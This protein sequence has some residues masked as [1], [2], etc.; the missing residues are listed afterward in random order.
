MS[1]DD[2]TMPDDWGFNQATVNSP[3][4]FT[5]NAPGSYFLPGQ[6]GNG[7]VLL[8][9]GAAGNP[10]NPNDANGT[11][12]DPFAYTNGSLLT[13]WTQQFNY[14]G[15]AAPEGGYF[16]GSAGYSPLAPLNYQDF[17]Y[18]FKAPQAYSYQGD[19]NAPTPFTA[20]R[21][22]APADFQSPSP[23]YQALRYTAPDAFQA[24][25]ESGMQEDPGY[26]F[27][28]KQGLQA[29]ENSAAA[30]GVLRSGNTYKALEDYGQ[31]SASNEYQN[32]YNRR[33]GE[34]TTNANLGLAAF[35]RN[36]AAGLTEN[37]L[38][39]SRAA[40]EYDRTYQNALQRYQMGYQQ[41]SSEH[42]RNF[43]EL[44]NTHNAN[45]TNSLEAWKGNTTADIQGQQLGFNIAS[46]TWDRNY[47]KAQTAYASSVQQAEQAAA[48]GAQNA[49]GAASA[50]E[51]AN[52]TNYNR[53]LGEYNMG[54]EQFQN[55]QVNQFSRIYSQ[56]ALGLQAAGTSS[57]Q[58]GQFA[59]N[60]SNNAT[61]QANANAA[62][63]IASGQA[64][65]NAITGFANTA[66]QAILMATT[67]RQLTY[68]GFANQ[69]VR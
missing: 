39:Y 4:N 2:V 58:A 15:P 9:P 30:R 54:Y 45:A 16:S 60:A 17:S 7:G 68:P 1:V 67:P 66:N 26:Q 47:G 25:G 13:P 32:V 64:N 23:A 61:G 52:S 36:S 55:N 48:I 38:N 19:I 53:A 6:G 31:E 33:F 35:D 18:G 28:T 14:N 65:A 3:G 50:A 44:Y 41:S 69:P 11:G 21:F 51:W 37:Q 49:A 42:D 20:D 46:G 63:Q 27:R 5:P 40:S 62:A 59:T 10:N 57:N 43:S 34:Y 29:L 12:A 8:P 56:Q 24:P 22:S